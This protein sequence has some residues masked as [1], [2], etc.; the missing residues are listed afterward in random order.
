VTADALGEPTST[1][2]YALCVYETSGP[3]LLTRLDAAPDGLCGANPQPCWKG[4]GNPAGSKGYQYKDPLQATGGLATLILKP[5]DAGRSRI[6]VTGKKDN[7]VLPPLP[8]AEPLALRAQ[9]K[10]SV[11]FCAEASYS[12]PITNSASAFRAMSD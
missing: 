4:L 11:G 5:G 7:L 6:T 9:L 12:I 10:S 1:T 2:R 3:T 8:L